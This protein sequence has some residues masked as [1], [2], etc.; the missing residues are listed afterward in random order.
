MNEILESYPY[1][2]DRTEKT[3]RLLSSLN[4]LTGFHQSHCKEYASILK[5]LGVTQ[6]QADR[7][8][9]VPFLPVR[10]FKHLDLRT[11]DPSEV[12]KTLT[13]SGTTGQA[14]SKIFLNRETAQR[15]T[16]ALVKIIQS[17]I[18]SDRVPMLI[19]DHPGVVKNPKSLSARGAGILGLSNFGRDHTYAL[20]DDGM[21]IDIDAVRRFSEKYAGKPKLLFGFTFMVWKFFLKEIEERNLDINLDNA[22]L[23]HSGGWKKLQS[24]AVTNSTF[25]AA[26]RNLAGINHVHNFYG[27]AEQV[28]SIFVECEHGV[29]H[30]PNFADVLVRNP[31]DWTP[32]ETNATGLIQVLSLLPTSYPGHSLITEDIGEI[33]GED[34]CACGRKGKYFRVY[35]RIAQAEVRGCSDTHS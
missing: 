5:T 24:E 34:D 22:T 14:V 10:V 28:G 6:I 16:R 19:V 31:L 12:I 1:G 4:D 3:S 25:K 2:L 21:A 20:S 32:M 15:Q 17:F 8:E 9:S 18:G 35:N 27:M 7:L 33:L 30:T 13:S 29:L 11:C 23:L 26:C